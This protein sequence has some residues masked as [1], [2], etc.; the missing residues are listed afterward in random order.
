M[1]TDSQM[2]A[3]EGGMGSG[4]G[5][6]CRTQELRF[7][8][9]GAVGDMHPCP[10]TLETVALQSPTTAPGIPSPPPGQAGT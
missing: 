4:P 7:I 9:M 1:L 10:V 8:P 6:G 2:G 3:H 5:L